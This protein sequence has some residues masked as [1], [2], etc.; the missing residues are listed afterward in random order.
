METLQ[1]GVPHART[2]RN[3]LD[4]VFALCVPYT[5]GL[6]EGFIREPVGAVSP[7]LC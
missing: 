4:L 5:E 1:P 3:Q 6:K 2:H 7:S